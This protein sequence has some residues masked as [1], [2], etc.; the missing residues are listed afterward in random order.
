MATATLDEAAIGAYC[1]EQGIYHFQ[2]TQWKE[3]FMTQ[4]T[5]IN[6]EIVAELKALREENKRLKKDLRRKESALAEASALLIL[7]KKSEIIWGETEGD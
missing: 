6:K 7:K 3:T 4:R 2:L 1:R 5:E